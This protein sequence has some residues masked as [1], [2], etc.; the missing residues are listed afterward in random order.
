M[1]RNTIPYSS[2][3]MFNVRCIL[4]AD[5][6]L[7]LVHTPHGNWP[8]GP[9]VFLFF[10]VCELFATRDCP[11]YSNCAKINPLST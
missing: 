4:V 2:I 10:L 8:F 3:S 7:A 6:S 5:C 11:A 1:L 9:V